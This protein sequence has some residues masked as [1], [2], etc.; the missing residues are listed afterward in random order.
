MFEDIE[1]YLKSLGIRD[2]DDLRS[3]EKETYFKMLEIAE[4]SKIDLETVKKHVRDMRMAVEFSLANEKLKKNED[5]FLKARLKNYLLLENL[6][7]R[8]DR[9]RQML[10]QYTKVKR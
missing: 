8:P 4:S 5:L 3:D 2:F 7:D 9:A 10:E 6:F 1:N